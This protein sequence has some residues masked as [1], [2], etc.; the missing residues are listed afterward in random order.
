MARIK[1]SEA[2]ARAR[3]AARRGDT[4]AARAI[5]GTVLE[6]FPG[7]RR[8]RDMLAELRA[9]VSAGP[10]AD[11]PG[12]DLVA[13]FEAGD[14]DAVVRLAQER[15][16]ETPTS[17][18][19][20]NIFGAALA[21]TGRP[22]SAVEAFGEATRLAPDHS[23]AHMNLGN[24]L[25]DLDRRDAAIAAYRKAIELRPG[26]AEAHYNLGRALQRAG[27]LAGAESAYRTA[28]SHMPDHRDATT[29]LWGLLLAA[30]RPAE[31]AKVLEQRLLAVPDD[32]EVRNNLGT[33]LKQQ[34]RIAEAIAT[35]KQAVE[36]AP[37]NPE[38]R[39][40]LGLTLRVAGD[41]RAAEDALRQAIDLSPGSS[42]PALVD[43]G[44]IFAETSRL[45]EAAHCYLEA[46]EVDLE[47]VFA[48]NNLGNLLARLGRE[49]EAG[50]CYERALAFDPASAEANN[51]M[52]IRRWTEGDL[53]GAKTH[54]SR[55][56]AAR[57]EM[58]FSRAQ[59]LHVEAQMCEF[60]SFDA[61]AAVSGTLGIEG[62]EV[63]PFATLAFEDS[64]ERQLARA[65]LYDQRRHRSHLPPLTIPAR[66]RRARLRIGY[67]SSDLYNHATLHLM[68]GLLRHHD[69]AR[70]E[71]HA[72]SYGTV[73]DSHQQ[74]LASGGMVDHFHDVKGF[75][76]V[77]IAE[78]ARTG[79]LDIAID[80][81]G[82]TQ[83]SRAGLLA[84]RVAPLQLSY[85]GYPG[86]LGAE[87]CD[88]IVADRHVIPE[89]ERP[90]Y[91]EKVI[92]LPDCY[93]PNDD[94][95][96]IAPID[97]TREDHGLPSEG[98]VLCCFNQSYKISRAEFDIWMRLLARVDGAVLWLLR[99]NRWA[100]ENLSRAAELRGIDPRRLVFAERCGPELHLARHRHA[101]LFVDTFNVNAHTTAT[102]ALWTGLP[103][104]TMQGRQFA[105]RVAGSLLHNVG[106]P[107]LVTEAPQA[108]E[109]LVLDL[110]LSPERLAVLRDRLTRARSIEPLFQTTRYA[111]H[112]ERGLDMAFE[113]WA[114]GL[115]P[116]DLH[117]PAG[118]RA[119][120]N[121]S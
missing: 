46:L 68:A 66:P 35:F 95:R 25:L 78:L 90:Y 88:Y 49:D 69:R 16:A 34:G 71:I 79:D 83:G 18:P 59:K 37:D 21:R 85:L 33:T 65:R 24:A 56:L 55:A 119:A 96:P 48:H 43:L 101:D 118:D 44:N 52:A 47:N 62:A 27:D 38:I 54:F 117:V 64:P 82:Y 112:F 14:H 100:E 113:R 102:D 114:S 41:D 60:E 104:V 3:S 63:P 15:L 22:D 61:F 80:L 30:E 107:E 20:W 9:P 57:P 36:V 17:A 32:A 6:N 23:S 94:L 12:Q 26:S 31:A 115:P 103:V 120:V 45:E 70:F 10:P 73:R 111:R 8:A 29:N 106:L 108:Y 58:A 19:I 87:W 7:N 39:R 93:Q 97:D 92:Y 53:P 5:C 99:T 98:F 89:A 110:M 116:D 109:S 81:K 121:S 86:S 13:L 75:S 1:V 28:L 105:A 74:D 77:A 40:N 84:D 11:A 51:N 4:E 72:F 91:S 67:F 50:A 42:A 2:I 76:D